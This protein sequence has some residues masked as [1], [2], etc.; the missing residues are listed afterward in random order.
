MAKTDIDEKIRGM[1]EAFASDL[2]GLIRESAMETVRDALGGAAP[3]GRRG[4]GR[5]ARAEAASPARRLPKGAKRPPGEIVKL[6]QRLLDYVKTHKGERIEQ[7]AKGM[8][9][10]TRELN[11]PVKK[12]ISTKAIK[13]RGQKRA[14]QYF[15]K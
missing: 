15:P 2:A 10:S 7:I 5:V 9:V 13:T 11:L 1:L 8:S 4:G 6:T 3:S 12:L 14:T